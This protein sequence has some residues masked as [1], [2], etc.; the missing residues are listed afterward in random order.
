MGNFKDC[1]RCIFFDAKNN[2]CKKNDLKVTPPV[3]NCPNY[4]EK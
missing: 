2:E 1:N 4:K 3:P